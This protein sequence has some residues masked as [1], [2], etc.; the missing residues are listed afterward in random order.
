VTIA[1][2]LALASAR[3]QAPAEGPEIPYEKYELPNG[4]DVILAPDPSTPIVHVNVWYWVGSKD[5][6]PGLTGFAHL[7]EH[8]MFQGSPSAPGD[9]F[10]LLENVGGSANGTTSF[11]RTN[12][13]ETVPS[14][15]L[16]LALFLESDRMGWLTDSLDQ[17][18][19]DNQREVV[20]N[21]RR[22]RYENPPYGEAMQT[23]FAAVWPDGHP[24]HHMPIG[25]HEDLQ[26]ASLE[27]VKA[28]FETWYAPDNAS[29]VIAGDFDPKVAKKLVKQYFGP[30][31]KGPERVRPAATQSPITENE[32]IRQYQKVPDQKVWVAWQSPAGFGPG[33][34]D[35]DVLSTI[36][37]DGRE[38]RL[39]YRLVKELGVAKDV[40]AYQRSQ[41]LGSMFV[42][43]ATA[44]KGHTT[45]EVV[46][47]IDQVMSE[48]LGAAPPTEEEVKAAQART[49]VAYWSAITTIGAKGDILNSYNY[50]QGDPGFI[51]EDLARYGAVT[52]RSMVDAGKAWLTRPRVVLHIWPEADRPAGGAQ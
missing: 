34:A 1:L 24:Y 32:E 14:E 27:A 35:L 10:Q 31:P 13:F 39:Q 46:A 40:S 4:L 43:T 2:L 38:S 12:Y 22:Q 37:S 8:I 42:I 9:Y 20:R 29:L 23:L 30:I 16:P 26:N 11:D 21:E 44:A 7:F 51:D 48:V 41:Q 45:D 5:E 18:R 3:A 28:F 47:A 49:E 33:D 17:A 6:K 19:L 15:Y 36:L 25:S 52:S 50:E